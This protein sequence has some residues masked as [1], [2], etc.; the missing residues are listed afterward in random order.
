[1]K[2]ILKF[3]LIPLFLS[4]LASQATLT[5]TNIAPGS[6]ARDSLFLKSDGSLW[7]MGDNTYGE[8]G[9]GFA[10]NG[11]AVPE[12]VVP[13]TQP[14]LSIA[15]SSQT[16]VQIN[17]KPATLPQAKCASTPDDSP[18]AHRRTGSHVG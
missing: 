14:V 5:V 9:D 4:A 3:S 13:A 15:L 16:N 12:Q 11:I 1:M 8:L 10:T 18:R 2:G 17:A 6:N 7:A